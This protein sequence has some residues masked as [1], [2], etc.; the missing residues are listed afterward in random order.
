M[1]EIEVRRSIHQ[2]LMRPAL[3]LIHSSC[4]ASDILEVYGQVD[5]GQE[6]LVIF[7]STFQGEKE[8]PSD[9]LQRLHSELLVVVRRGSIE[10]DAVGCHLTRQFIQCCFDEGLLQKLRL[11]EQDSDSCWDFAD[12]L[13]EVR[14]KVQEERKTISLEKEAICVY[15]SV[16]IRC[17]C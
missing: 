8:S 14:R 2:S 10:L 6:L 1:S 5:N 12:L 4:S 15:T 11:E 9:Y 3:D 16:Y 17:F 7:F 13:V